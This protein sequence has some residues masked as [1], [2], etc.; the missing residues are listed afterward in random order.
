M[1][2]Y[3]VRTL[4]TKPVTYEAVC[5]V[6]G[7]KDAKTGSTWKTGAKATAKTAQWAMTVHVGCKHSNKPRKPRKSPT[8][9]AE[10]VKRSKPAAPQMINYCPCCKFPIGV[11]LT[12]ATQGDQ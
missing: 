7:C 11:L 8:P 9:K 3:K 2:E 5:P 12:L 6:A 4:N 1:P 10:P